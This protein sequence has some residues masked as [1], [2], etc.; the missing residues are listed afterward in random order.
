ME[1]IDLGDGLE[2]HI[3]ENEYDFSTEGFARLVLSRQNKSNVWQIHTDGKWWVTER[4]V[5]QLI[6][7]LQYVKGAMK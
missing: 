5:D 4:D 6:Q 2:V 1:T 3:S 7:C